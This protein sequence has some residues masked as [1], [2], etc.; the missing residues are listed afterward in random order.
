[1]EEYLDMMLTERIHGYLHH[2]NLI[3]VGKPES[4]EQAALIF[5]S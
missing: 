2:A 1:M 4:I 5:K 3:D